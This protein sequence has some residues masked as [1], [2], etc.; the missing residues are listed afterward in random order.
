MSTIKKRIN[1][2]IS[3]S[4][5]DI[6]IKLS[7]RDQVPQATKACELLQ[8]AVEMEE[9]SYFNKIASKRLKEST[10]FVSHEEAWK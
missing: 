4:L 8:L 1:I 6:L 3:K 2:S 9:D 5:D 10:G 7:K